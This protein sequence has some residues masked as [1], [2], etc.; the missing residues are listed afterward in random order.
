MNIQRSTK[1]IRDISLIPLINV[2][3][4]LVIFFLIAGH[5]E[6]IEILPVDPPFA[7]SSSEAHQSALVIVLGRYDEILANDTLKD[8]KSLNAW[9]QQ[10]LKHGDRPVTIRADARL[11]APRLIQV[12]EMVKQAGGTQVT[13]AAQQP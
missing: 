3:F 12:M 4:L 8:S 1:P 9:L 11:S 6:R 2:I 7:E 13:I 5:L 10:E